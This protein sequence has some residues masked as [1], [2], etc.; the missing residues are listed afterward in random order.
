MHSSSF[1]M[2]E[3]LLFQ[4]QAEFSERAVQFLSATC[5]ADSPETDSDREEDMAKEQTSV[6]I[7]EFSLF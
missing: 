7:T 4:L 2:K 5:G 1:Y 3:A 6:T